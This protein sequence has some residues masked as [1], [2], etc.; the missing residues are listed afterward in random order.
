MPGSIVEEAKDPCT[1]EGVVGEGASDGDPAYGS[2]YGGGICGVILQAC[3]KALAK[4]CTLPK[5][6]C[7]SFA[8]AVSTTCSSSGEM[9]GIFSDKGGGGIRICWLAISV[10]DPSKG[11][12]PHSH[13][14]TTIPRAYWSLA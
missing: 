2:P 5:R 12:L 1:S 8:R 14:Y 3:S 10:K 13:S 6:R 4:A 9:V 11:H 7:G